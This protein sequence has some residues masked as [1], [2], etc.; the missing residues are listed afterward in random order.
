MYHTLVSKDYVLSLN[1]QF[2]SSI[3]EAISTNKSNGNNNEFN[4]ATIVSE[5]A[6]EFDL[7]QF[8]DTATI[9]QNGMD[10]EQQQKKITTIK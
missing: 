1:N 2:S 3:K 9:N 10:I 8:V 5:L 6:K 4:T 7:N